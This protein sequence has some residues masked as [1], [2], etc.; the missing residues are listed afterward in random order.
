M[1]TNPPNITALP[2]PPDP[3]DRSSFNVRAYPWS[4]AQ[5]TLATEV[6]A[7]AANVKGN[8]DEAVAAAS[9]A[10]A[11]AGNASGSASAA[12]AS[13]ASALNA[14]GTNATSSTNLT[15][16]LGPQSFVIQSGKLF[17][18]G[19]PFVIARTAA[20]L[21]QM[22]GIITAHN[23]VT[24]AVA[25]T[26]TAKNGAGTYSDWTVSLGIVAAAGPAA[27][28]RSPRS[29]GTV[30][31]APDKGTWVDITSGT[32]A[33]TFA[34][35][36]ALDIGWWCYLGN[37]GPGD[38]TLVPNGA[39]TIDGLASYVMY[40]GELRLIQCDGVSLRSI[41][42]NGYSKTV[43]ASDSWKKPPGYRHH[44]GLLWGG[45][46][47]GA[48][49]NASTG[50]AVSGSGGGACFPF[51]IA[52]ANLPDTV[53]VTIGA[54]GAAVTI[55]STNGNVGGTSS[56]GSFAYAY[57]GGP[58]SY[59]A[60]AGYLMGGGGGGAQSAGGAGGT[61][62]AGL[63]GLPGVMTSDY[64]GNS[65][66]IYK[67]VSSGF[68]GAAFGANS[69]TRGTTV[70]GGANGQAA[71]YDG[72]SLYASEPMTIYGGGGGGAATATTAGTGHT[73]IF[74]GAGG[75]GSISGNASAGSAPGGGGGSTRTGTQS[76]AGARGE[77]RIWGVI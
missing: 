30:L 59:N 48:K 47:S 69:G 41:V 46:A 75:A 50:S 10:I 34:A 52:A 4:V 65:Q 49:G 68:G 56:F 24:G 16:G 43:T 29:S 14:P 22:S 61:I 63:P 15:V 58:G 31:S 5:Q 3:N 60:A 37:S 74:G 36:A 23:P 9:T 73:S 21:V 18:V 76:G 64:D 77:F 39:E 67:P 66:T 12:A 27:L 71:S 40:P 32:F 54:G 42:V 45:G 13:A 20:P 70:Y 33:Q 7:V 25:G 55:A 19:Q 26:V 53:T 62:G 44:S 57:G 6:A 72:S 28:V 2:S 17:S 8:A 11:Q 35:A 51:Q 38:V 1:P